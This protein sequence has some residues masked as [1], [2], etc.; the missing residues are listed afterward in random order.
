MPTCLAALAQ[1]FED[2]MAA[3]PNRTA[4]TVRLWRRKLRLNLCESAEASARY[5]H[6]EGPRA[7]VQPHRRHARSVAHRPLAVLRP[8][9]R[10]RCVDH[11]GLR[12]PLERWLAGD[13]RFDRKRCRRMCVQPTSWR[14]GEAGH[15]RTVR[16][17]RAR[18]S[19]VARPATSPSGRRLASCN[20]SPT[21]GRSPWSG[22]LVS[23]GR[24]P[25]GDLP[26]GR[27]SPH[28]PV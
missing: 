25:S 27:S 14:A 16:D 15:S 9:E 18:G 24:S 3:N 12:N 10:R 4:N 1:A 17:D 7:P 2:D 26:R 20:G 5:R 13:R 6:R 23:T 11:V 19:T 28:R 21:S 8:L 22:P